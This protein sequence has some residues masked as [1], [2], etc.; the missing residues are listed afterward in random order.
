MPQIL[1]VAYGNPMRCDDGV[2]WRA[3]E[4]LE[5]DFHPPDVQILRL[6][7]LTPELADTVSRFQRV[8][9]VD[10]ASAEQSL[11]GEIRI[12]E[13]PA[14][15]PNDPARFSHVLSPQT[16]VVLA[17]KLYGAKLQAFLATVTGENFDHG[18]SLS[19]PVAAALPALVARVEALVQHLMSTAIR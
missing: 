15:D 9:F 3:A 16:V 14:A 7:Q 4:I 17:A 8:I 11:P 12:E 5:K 10:A 13:L 18:D 1:I 2:A 19:L 6:H